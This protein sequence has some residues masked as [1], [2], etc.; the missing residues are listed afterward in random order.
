VHSPFLNEKP[1][2]L[3][4]KETMELLEWKKATTPKD[5][6]DIMGSGQVDFFC[7]SVSTLQDNC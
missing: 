4:K 3:S 6:F 5:L 1:W 7:Q 2:G